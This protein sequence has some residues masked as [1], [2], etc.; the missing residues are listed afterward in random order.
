M[1]EVLK[2]TFGLNAAPLPA[3]TPVPPPKPKTIWQLIDENNH[4]R[5]AATIAADPSLLADTI[6]C[7]IGKEDI[8]VTPALYAA[9]KG[10]KVLLALLHKA[11]A[12]I[13]AAGGKGYTPLHLAARSRNGEKALEYIL[14]Q[15][16]ANIEAKTAAGGTPLV[17]AARQGRLGSVQA[18][19]ARGAKADAA[20]EQAMPAIVAAAAAGQ[21]DVVRELLKAG[22]SIDAKNGA[23]RTALWYAVYG[24]QETLAQELIARRADIGIAD[25]HGTTLLMGAARIGNAALASQLLEAGLDINARDKNGCTALHYTCFADAGLRV[26]E[27]AEFLIA[28]G[29]YIDTVDK[30]GEMPIDRARRLKSTWQAAMTELF[31]SKMDDPASARDPAYL[32]PFTEG[33]AEKVIAMKALK[34]RPAVNQ[35]KY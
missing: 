19:L 5:L 13:D 20:A 1:L 26:R 2:K 15:S 35:P 9:H 7:T 11:G 31:Q 27:T 23:G 21:Q 4:E 18:L 32:A 17:E 3:P 33:A 29:A 10:R 28:H 8:R 34:L 25:A 22:A 16:T 12:D 24:R 6:Q 30:Q 14:S